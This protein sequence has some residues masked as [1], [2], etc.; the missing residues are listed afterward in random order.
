M[1]QE[2][3]EIVERYFGAAVRALDAYWDSPRSMAQALVGHDLDG[4]SRQVLDLMHP[5]MRW[6]NA[7]GIVFE[8][9][10][11][12]AR[13]FD[14]LME[15]SQAYSATVTEVTDLADDRVLAVLTVE[16]NGQSS[17]AAATV[18]IYSVLSLRDG[19]IA[20]ADEYLN[21]TEA[22]K[23]VGLEE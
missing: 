3:V 23:A 21:R 13:G 16:M 22:L 19:L 5:D 7:A 8:G 17:G 15:T 2:N 12:C 4:D 20:D 14:E 18:S 9:K 1:S 6:K 11:G 10:H